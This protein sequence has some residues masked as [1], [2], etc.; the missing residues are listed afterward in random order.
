[1]G[2]NGVMWHDSFL[3]CRYLAQV[4]GFSVYCFD[5]RLKHLHSLRLKNVRS[6]RFSKA[7]ALIQK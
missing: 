5:K 3:P 2:I 1:M 7:P 4:L 6:L